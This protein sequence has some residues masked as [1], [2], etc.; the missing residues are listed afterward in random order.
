VAALGHQLP[1][2][3]GVGVRMNEPAGLTSADDQPNLVVGDD[4]YADWHGGKRLT[5]S[6]GFLVSFPQPGQ[7]VLLIEGSAGM[8]KQCFWPGSSDG[9]DRP[10]S[11]SC[12]VIARGS[13]V[14]FRVRGVG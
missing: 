7:S 14:S 2:G 10:G 13:G 5:R 6:A 4:V 3:C 8:G 9:G 12:L 1:R 11:P